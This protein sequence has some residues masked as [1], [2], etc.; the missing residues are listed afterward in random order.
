[1]AYV[2]PVELFSKLYLQPST[3]PLLEAAPTILNAPLAKAQTALVNENVMKARQTRDLYNQIMGGQ[4][5]ALPEGT[6]V[7]DMLSNPLIRS[8]LDLPQMEYD[9]FNVYNQDGTAKRISVPKGTNYELKQGESFA[10]AASAQRKSR[11]YM[12]NGI[13]YVQ[14]YD[15]DPVLATEKLVG[16]PYVRQEQKK[17][18]HKWYAADGTAFE[19]DFTPDEWQTAQETIRKSGGSLD[20]PELTPQKK[21]ERVN[22][23][24]DERANIFKSRIAIRKSNTLDTFAA[25]L[26][27]KSGLKA[28]VAGATVSPDLLDE[29]DAALDLALSNIDAELGRLG[30]SVS[31]SPED[32][33]APESESNVNDY[34]KRKLSGQK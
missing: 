7:T 17:T 32:S 11:E 23:L 28:P 29:Y 12:K 33:G 2:N 16:E 1:M 3:T 15:Y 20:K 24:L 27:Q 5:S 34:I 13:T 22:K 19:D 6:Q 8:R 14:D 10:K 4:G 21:Q 31:D 9:T 30:H 26:G 18:T 25:I